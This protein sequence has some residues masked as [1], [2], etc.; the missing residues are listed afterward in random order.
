M[1]MYAYIYIYVYVYIYAVKY[2]TYLSICFLSRSV[3]GELDSSE[4]SS[5]GGALA[6]HVTQGAIRS[7]EVQWLLY[8]VIMVVAL[9]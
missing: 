5:H 3:P 7:V 6:L 4:L 8:C 1:Y 2:N 9:A